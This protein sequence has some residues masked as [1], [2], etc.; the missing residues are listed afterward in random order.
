MGRPSH[1]RETL[2][3][4]RMLVFD[5][6]K[7]LGAPG[8]RPIAVLLKGKVSVRIVQEFVAEYKFIQRQKKTSKRMDVVG[9]NV[10][11][12]MDGAITKENEKIENQVIKDRGTKCWV[13]YK[14]TARAS[15]AA[16]VI[17]TLKTSFDK[18]GKPLV[19][20][21][22]NGAAYTNKKVCSFL[23]DLKIIH[24]RSLPRTPQH[25]GSVEVGI[26][27]LREIMENNQIILKEAMKVANARPRKYGKN[28]HMP[29]C[30][31]EN[32]DVPYNK[33]D[34]ELFFKTCDEKLSNLKMKSMGFRERRMRERELV[35]EELARKGFVTEWKMTK[36][37]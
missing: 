9:K 18:N 20:S 10:I 21:T 3:Q 36:N 24:L 12:T 34:R 6:M 28:W 33:F 23:R 5:E 35:F 8:W 25:N 17:E 26:K 27:E 30:T 11:W 7:K 19:L 4:S 13:G 1:S 37:G 29:L 14:K 31:F 15:N 2:E 22:D 32:T 16:D